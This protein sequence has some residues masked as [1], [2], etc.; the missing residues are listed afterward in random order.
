M[1]LSKLWFPAT[2]T[3]GNHKSSTRQEAKICIPLFRPCR[4]EVDHFLVAGEFRLGLHQ[5]LLQTHRRVAEVLCRFLI[6][7]RPICGASGHGFGLATSVDGQCTL[8]VLRSTN[9]RREDGDTVMS[10]TDTSIAHQIFAHSMA[11][12]SVGGCFPLSRVF[13][14][15]RPIVKGK[16]R[17]RPDTFKVLVSRDAVAKLARSPRVVGERFCVHIRSR[18]AIHEGACLRI[19]SE[20]IRSQMI[21]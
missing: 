19:A 3:R 5:R 12:I 20:D 15:Q 9:A 16:H 8:D 17:C 6:F 21:E 4:G 10:R 7:I 1:D 14:N 18:F 13:A 2:Q 11:E